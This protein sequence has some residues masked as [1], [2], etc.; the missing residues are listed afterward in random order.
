[1]E[2]ITK[3]LNKSNALVGSKIMTIQSFGAD[4]VAP[5]RSKIRRTSISSTDTT[6]E[7]L[8][9]VQAYQ[10]R[11]YQKRKWRLVGD[12]VFL[13][14]LGTSGAWAV[15]FK[16]AC[17]Y[18]VGSALGALYL[19]LLSRFVESVGKGGGGEGGGGGGGG[20]GSGRL[21]VAGLLVLLCAKNKEVLDLV[22]ALGGF[23]MY[24]VATLVQG[25]YD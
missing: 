15:S 24:Q 6:D 12:H 14:I 5:M 25:T 11:L 21:G 10:A 8:P 13:G 19:V 17:S 2:N 18:G 3:Q 23:L 7:R 20:G 9:K 1:M 4:S 16:A 22:P